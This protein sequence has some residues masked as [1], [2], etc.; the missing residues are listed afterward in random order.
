MHACVRRRGTLV[1][2]YMPRVF[3][4]KSRI[5]RR[6]LSHP[7]GIIRTSRLDRMTISV[8]LSRRTYSYVV[9]VLRVPIKSLRNFAFD[10]PRTSLTSRS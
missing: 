4:A 3:Q 2:T 9:R 8:I 6:A 5:S 10:A 1:I 7:R